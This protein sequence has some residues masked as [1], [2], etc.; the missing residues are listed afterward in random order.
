MADRSNLDLLAGLFVGALLAST[1]PGLV[2]GFRRRR[3]SPPAQAFATPVRPRAD[4]RKA[5]GQPS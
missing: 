1:L 4:P 2:R 3:R 5:E